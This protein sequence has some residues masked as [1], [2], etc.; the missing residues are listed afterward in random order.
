[1]ICLITCTCFL[2]VS[3]DELDIVFIVDSSGSI[4]EMDESNWDKMLSFIK[5]VITAFGD[6]GKDIRYAMVVYSDSA[7]VEFTLNR[8]NNNNDVLSQVDKTTYFGGRTDIADGLQTAREQI[9]IQSAGYHATAQN[10]VILITDGIPNERMDDTQ[11]EANLIKQL[12]A[13]LATVGITDAVDTD[14]LRALATD[15]S[16]FFS[17]PT[18]A[19]LN[20]IVRRL[21]ESACPTV[22][23]QPTSK[24]YRL[25]PLSIPQNKQH[26]WTDG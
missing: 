12:G 22:T 21:V 16:D 8:F 23:P 26:G 17:S 11:S 2:A 18:F 9:L 20:S 24:C 3:C 25:S 4:K 1:M 13:K 7:I 10:I 14:L 6:T 19:A 15:Q 5:N